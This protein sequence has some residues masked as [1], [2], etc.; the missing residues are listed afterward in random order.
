[1]EDA[2][3]SDLKGRVVFVTG[4][5]RGIGRAI[6][7]RCAALGAR[8]VIAAKSDVPHHTLEGTIHSV[9]EEVR[10]LGT[11]ALPVRVDVR[12]ASEIDAAVA[13]AVEEFG[14][15]D[16]LVNNA[17][18]IAL[19]GVRALPLKRFDLM[20]QV[21]VRG[22]YACARAC[23]PHLMGSANPHILNISPPLTT[24]ASWLGRHLGSAVSKF[25][26][27]MCALGFAEELKPFGIAANALWPRTLI[28][29][30]ATRVFFPDLVARTRHPRIMADAA[31]WIISQDSRRMTGRTLIDEDVLR[32]AGVTDLSEYAV[33]P[34]A[35]LAPDIY[36]D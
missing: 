27:T 30:D 5:S 3:I 23:L 15:I 10:A 31:A 19:E 35:S 18:A 11:D 8:I 22:S 28:L 2:L 17:G 33:Q 13:R 34:R 14:G 32:E 9:A 6:A 20:M 25:G 7:L 16:V 12:D 21:N 1:M 26:M 24:R 4:A 29:T 36:L